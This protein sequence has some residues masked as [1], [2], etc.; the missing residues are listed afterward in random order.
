MNTPHSA[1]GPEPVMPW[2]ARLLGATYW[3]GDGSV[4]TRIGEIAYR[5]RGIGLKIGAY[6]DVHL[7]LGLIFFGWY[8]K[9]PDRLQRF[10]PGGCGIDRHAYGFTWRWAES[11]PGIFWNWG[12]R[13]G[14]I[15]MPWELEH[16]R[17]EYLGTD[18]QWWDARAQPDH[19]SRRLGRN[20]YTG[21]DGPPKWS[22]QH[23]YRY[24]LSSGEVQERIAT[25]TRRRAFHGRH[26]FGSGPVSSLLRKIMP[27]KR[28]ESIDV[29]F[30]GEVGDRS[31]SWK[32]GC[33]GCSYDIKPEES[34]RAA[35]MRMQRE[36]RF[37]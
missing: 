14:I 19:Y 28:F 30:N 31:G 13:S 25:I 10:F 17:T 23:P 2:W 24:L 15:A 29:E 9:L 12:A 18:G 35:L 6:E 1:Y 26:W 33:I 20:P 7:F 16:I 11:L 5:Q 22:E 3:A 32:G 4:R 21:P 34:P 8:I 36:R 27:M 37:R